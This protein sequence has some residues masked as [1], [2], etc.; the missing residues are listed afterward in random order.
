MLTHRVYIFLLRL[1]NFIDKIEIFCQN[2]LNTINFLQYIM[3]V[4]KRINSLSRKWGDNCDNGWRH[5]L[6]HRAEE[7]NDRHITNTN[8]S[9]LNI[10]IP[11]SIFLNFWTY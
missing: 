3:L 10:F 4:I 9:I 1:I 5:F 8:K 2:H 6:F 11:H 7:N